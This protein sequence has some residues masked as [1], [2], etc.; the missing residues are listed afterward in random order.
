[1]LAEDLKP[2]NEARNPPN[3]WIEQKGKR[4]RERKEKKKEGVI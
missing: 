4:E 1:M 3:N 2:P